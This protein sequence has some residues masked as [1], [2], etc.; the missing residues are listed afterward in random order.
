MKI[1]NLQGILPTMVLSAIAIVSSCTKDNTTTVPSN[2]K[3]AIGLQL[4]NDSKFGKIL[5]DSLGKSLYFFANDVK[6]ISTC[7]AGCLSVWPIYYNK[8]A[9]I[10]L[11][12][13]KTKVGEITRAD[14][15]KQTTYKGW[16]LYYF[17]NDGTANDIKGDGV[18]KIWFVAKPDYIMMVANAQ[19]TGNDT[20]NY[21]ESYQPGE[22]KTIYFTDDIGRTLYA[23]SP[24]KFNK[25]TFTAADFS[26]DAVWPIY[27]QTTGAFPSII[28]K[29][30]VTNIDVFGKKQLTYKGWPLYYF[31]QDKSRGDNKGVSVPRPGIWPIT[32][33][34]TVEASK[35]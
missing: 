20:K 1:K 35:G 13:D 29:D 6:G 26:N 8:N 5:T 22:G 11:G 10:D 21:L 34:N 31:G 27:Q 32:N 30:M 24:D 28:A 19:L 2:D 4:K 14:G 7:T 3:P 15:Q 17:A 16:P 25:N 18:Q 12:L 9:S 23:F 33:L